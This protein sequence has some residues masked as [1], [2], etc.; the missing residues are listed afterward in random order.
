M[1]CSGCLRSDI[2]SPE[3]P[4]KRANYDLD[5]SGGGE[6]AFFDSDDEYDDYYDDHHFCP[7]HGRSEFLHEMFERMF[8]S[9]YYGEEDDFDEY[10]FGGNKSWRTKPRTHSRYTAFVFPNPY[11]SSI[12]QVP[13]GAVCE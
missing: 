2:N 11:Q 7:H 13:I 9:H 10:Y 5:P 3:D 6:D 8:F 4:E 1:S 12:P